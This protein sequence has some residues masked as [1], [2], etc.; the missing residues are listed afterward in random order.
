MQSHHRQC[1]GGVAADWQASGRANW[2]GVHEELIRG[3]NDPDVSIVNQ[4]SGRCS[5]KPIY[6]PRQSQ[7]RRKVQRNTSRCVPSTQ[8][9]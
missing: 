4:Q 7:E 2:S 1:N 5:K 3:G 6:H 9:K 8:F